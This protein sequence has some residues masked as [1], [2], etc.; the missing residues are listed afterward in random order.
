M[1]WSGAKRQSQPA[2]TGSGG[3][4]CRSGGPG[5]PGTDPFYP[6]DNPANVRDTDGDGCSDF[7]ELNFDGFCDNDP[8]TPSYEAFDGFWLE[9][10]PDDMANSCD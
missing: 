2:G 3:C 6:T 8:N 9:Y 7:D 5:T 4:R 1:K 10:L